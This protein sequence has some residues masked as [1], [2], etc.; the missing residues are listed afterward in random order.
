[1]PTILEGGCH[2]GNIRYRFHSPLEL[3]S[4]P[5]RACGC[6]FC[7]RIRGRHTSHPNGRLEATIQHGEDVHNYRFGTG[8]ADFVICRRCG[9]APYVLSRIEGHLY[10]VLNVNTLDGDPLGHVAPARSDFEGETTEARLARRKQ[11]WIGEVHVQVDDG[12]EAR[13]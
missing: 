1:M 10:A 3:G 7:T 2:C 4:I 8:T 9:G 12:K 11:K 13:L 5:V 6:S